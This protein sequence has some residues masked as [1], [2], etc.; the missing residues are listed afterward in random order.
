MDNTEF[1]NNLLVELKHCDG[2]HYLIS[3][4]HTFPG[5]M[6]AYCELKKITFCV[7]LQEISAMSNEANYWIKGFLNGNEPGP[8]EEYDYESSDDYFNSERYKSW[9]KSMDNFRITGYIDNEG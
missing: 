3:N 7:S 6:N 1:D 9:L 5:R 2:K 4:C 8:P